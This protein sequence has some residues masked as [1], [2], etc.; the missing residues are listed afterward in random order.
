MKLVVGLGNPGDKYRQTRHNVGF[1]VLGE[2]ARRGGGG[3]ATV[4]HQAE[5]T[6]LW[7]GQEKVLLACPLTFMN[8]SGQSV[9]AIVK[10]HKLEL[11]DLLVVCDDL[12]LALGRIRLRGQ[13]SSGGQKGLEDIIRALGSADFARLRVGIDAVPPGWDAADYVL[14]RFSAAEKPVV[15]QAID[16]AAEAVSVWLQAG[17]LDAMNRFNSPIGQAAGERTAQSSAP[18]EPRKTREPREPRKT[19]G[20]EG[21]SGLPSDGSVE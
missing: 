6:E 18:S 8:R 21:G 16:R 1:E 2:V 11:D 9:A 19:R 20:S 13:G 7:V 5:L 3:R 17:L 15:E 14:S 10:F 4:K 12:N